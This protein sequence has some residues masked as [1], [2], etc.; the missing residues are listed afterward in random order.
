MSV[1][2]MTWAWE[3]D[4]PEGEKMVLLAL[5]DH[6]DDRGV[7]WPGQERIAGKVGCSGRTVARRLESLERAGLISRTARWGDKGR[8][9]DLITLSLLADYPTERLPDKLTT[10]HPCQ[11]N[12]K[13]PSTPSVEDASHSSG[14]PSSDGSPDSDGKVGAGDPSTPAVTIDG[15]SLSDSEW[16]RACAIVDEFNRLAGSSYAL[17]GERGDAT[18]SLKRIVMRLRENPEVDLDEHLAILGRVFA[19]PWWEPETRPR[20]SFVYG[21]RAFPRALSGGPRKPDRPYERPIGTGGE[22]PW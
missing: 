7:C 13:N 3:R 22:A 5:A 16:A 21:P 6:A 10:S 2:A 9:S 14:N 18:D 19:D 20:P 17:I 8:T 4:I 12:R 15:K 11:G 1:K